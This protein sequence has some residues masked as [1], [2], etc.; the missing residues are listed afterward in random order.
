[1][2]QYKPPKPPLSLKSTPRYGQVYWCDFSI[3]N[4]LPEFDDVH[5]VVIIRS[6]QSLDRPHVVLPMTSRDH[7]GDV[8]AYP[9]PNNPNPKHPETTSWVI[10]N[11]P[12]TVASERLRPMRDR[13]NNNAF[14][15]L[16]TSDLREIGI[17]LR[18]AL[19]RLLTDSVS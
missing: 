18:L 6:G 5:P 1:M 12:Y 16:P 10:C 14:P 3:S 17:L 15:T 13:Y 19:R 4:V 8:Y 7:E 11:Q 9:L 2:T